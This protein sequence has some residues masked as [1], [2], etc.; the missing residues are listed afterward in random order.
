MK[1]KL[2]TEV[3]VNLINGFCAQCF[4]DTY[5]NGEGEPKMIKGGVSYEKQAEE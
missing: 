3:F 1:C 5:G 2:C 4:K